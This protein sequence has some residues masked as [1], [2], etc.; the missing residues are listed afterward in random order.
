MKNLI[1]DRKIRELFIPGSHDSASFKKNFNPEYE[2]TLIT[3]YSLTQDDDVRS[4]LIH[5]EYF[6]AVLA[7]DYCSLKSARKLF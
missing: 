3:K 7:E 1:K 6:I 2:E 4:Q 5:G